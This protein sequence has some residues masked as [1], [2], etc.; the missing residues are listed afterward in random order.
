MKKYV[1]NHNGKWAVKNSH[2]SRVSKTFDTQKEAIDYAKDLSETTSI[3]V[4]SRSGSFRSVE[5]KPKASIKSSK[6]VK[7]TA[8]KKVVATPKKSTAKKKTETT[9]KTT[10]KKIVDTPKKATSSKRI[11]APNKIVPTKNKGKKM[12]EIK[13][14]PIDEN[15]TT[16]ETSKIKVVAPPKKDASTE[17]TKVVASKE[18]SKV[19]QTPDNNASQKTETPKVVSSKANK[20]ERPNQQV[21]TVNKDSNSDEV[22]KEDVKNS[23]S[24]EDKMK[25]HWSVKMTLWI[26]FGIMMVIIIFAILVSV[27]VSFALDLYDKFPSWLQQIK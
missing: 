9:P 25:L 18:S 5:H 22:N 21:A 6:T 3:M 17:T 11:V 2:A 1:I 12:N 23:S 20:Q 16:N 14:K 13:N 26:L 19:I 7:K 24:S 15:K 4:Q 27:N 8:P 10:T